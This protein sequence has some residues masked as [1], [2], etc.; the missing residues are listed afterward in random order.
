MRLS[1]LEPHLNKKKKEIGVLYVTTPRLCNLASGFMLFKLHFFCLYI[2]KAA[3]LEYAL[4]LKSAVISTL[5]HL[6]FNQK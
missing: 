6:S 1:Y 5:T 2:V 4:Y 3:W